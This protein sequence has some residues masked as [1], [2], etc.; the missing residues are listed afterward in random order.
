MLTLPAALLLHRFTAHIVR[1]CV[2]HVLMQEEE[3]G[4][5][6]TAALRLD[7]TQKQVTDTLYVQPMQIHG[8]S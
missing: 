7:A 8:P 6:F 2:Q 1:R 5:E 4:G 3:T